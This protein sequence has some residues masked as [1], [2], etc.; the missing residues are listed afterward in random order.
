MRIDIVI[1]AGLA[2]ALGL[3]AGIHITSCAA[4]A[5]LHGHRLPILTCLGWAAVLGVI[6]VAFSVSIR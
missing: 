4:L 6:L 3:C 5:A 1:A 2:E